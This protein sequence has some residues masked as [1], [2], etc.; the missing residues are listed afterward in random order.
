M[1]Q[2]F[3]RCEKQIYDDQRMYIGMY[4]PFT[5]K[6]IYYAQA[7]VDMQYK[8]PSVLPVSNS[9]N[10]MISLSNKT[11]GK[12]FTSLMVNVLPDI[13]LFAGGSQNV[14]E[15]LYDAMG[16]FSAIRPEVLKKLAELQK[17]NA[18]LLKKYNG[19]R[20]DTSRLVFGHSGTNM[21]TT[22]DYS[23][24]V[25]T[26]LGKTYQ[27]RISQASIGITTGLNKI[28]EGATLEQ[29]AASLP[30]AVLGYKKEWERIY[31]NNPRRFLENVMQ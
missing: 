6:Y 18:V 17:R 13:N 15:L 27:A 14:P 23:A 12:K 24:I 31:K 8:M 3:E 5:K 28:N 29:V 10:Q 21:Q 25:C 4:R 11:E 26:E 22:I 19:D 9:K 7:W 1:K 16:S 20:H 2:R 30:N